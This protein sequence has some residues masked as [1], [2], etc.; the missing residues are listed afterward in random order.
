MEAAAGPEVPAVKLEARV[1]VRAAAAAAPA[2]MLSNLL[3]LSAKRAT[4]G[5][6]P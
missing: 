5:N 6:R 2:F 3:V 1:R 4:A